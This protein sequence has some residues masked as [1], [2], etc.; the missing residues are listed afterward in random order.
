MS[1]EL[2]KGVLGFPSLLATLAGMFVASSTLVS[3]GQ[4]VG[5]GGTSFIAAM[6]IAALLLLFQSFTF[7][8]L[9][10]MLPRAGS[11][12][13]YTEIALGHF[14]AIVASIAGYVVVQLLAG[15]ADLT[16]AGAIV[17]HLFFPSVSPKIFA[18]LLLT[19]FVVLNLLGIDLFANFQIALAVLV[20][21]SISSVGLA[22]FFQTQPALPLA[23]LAF[24][25]TGQIFSLVALAIWLFI[26]IEFV[27]P[28]IEESKNPRR[29]I[30]LAMAVALVAALIMQSLHGLTAGRFVPA[31]T[32]AQSSTPHLE[33]ARSV[34]GNLGYY[35]MGAISF[36]ATG[37][38]VNV[39]MAGVPRMLYGMAHAGQVPAIFKYIHPRYKTP[40]VGIL[41]LSAG[42]A[43]QVVLGISGT[44][45][46]VALIVAASFSWLLAYVVAH[47]DVV[48]LRYRYPALERPFRTPLY[49]V[50]QLLGIAGI[51][52]VMFHIFPDPKTASLIYR[53]ALY[54]LA[55][56]AIYAYLWC[57]FKLKHGLFVPVT[58]EQ[59]MKE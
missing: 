51:G 48:V 41:L 29:H 5:V 9:A 11:I 10:L 23:P 19:I 39:L 54:F 4:G 55:G 1:T 8:E 46:I 30:P 15:P 31:A 49:P 32:L 50:P 45:T 12:S 59:A 17:S 3:L 33:I 21:F 52:Y 14:P 28:L 16:I 44:E 38:V 22:G 13:S 25:D 56:T 47:I 34:L 37:S 18:L 27:C 53:Y 24:S 36:L 43:L 6:V 40:W 26:G 35:W 57:K 7:S 2:K 58:H 42:M 20:I